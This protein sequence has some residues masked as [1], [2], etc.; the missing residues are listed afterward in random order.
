MPRLLALV[1]AAGNLRN[2]HSGLRGARALSVVARHGSKSISRYH[3]SSFTQRSLKRMRRVYLT[4]TYGLPYGGEIKPRIISIRVATSGGRH[5]VDRRSRLVALGVLIFSS[6]DEGRVSR[7]TSTG[8]RSRIRRF[9]SGVAT[10]ASGDD[11]RYVPVTAARC[12]SPVLATGNEH[13]DEWHR[14]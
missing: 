4:G 8:T 3:G 5:E 9:Q 6:S 14:F 13:H 10:T 7:V 1:I 11:E 2:F 12:S